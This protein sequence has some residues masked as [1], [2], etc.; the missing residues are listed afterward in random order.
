MKFLTKKERRKDRNNIPKT[1]QT[2]KA[3]VRTTP[4]TIPTVQP[5]TSLSKKTDIGMK[6]IIR[7]I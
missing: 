1:V 7:E 3:P 2:P 6:K 5:S 4:P